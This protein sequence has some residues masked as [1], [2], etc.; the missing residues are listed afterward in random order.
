MHGKNYTCLI[1]LILKPEG[2]RPL[3]KCNCGR[4]DNIR[5]DFEKTEYKSVKWI[6]V[7]HDKS[8]SRKMCTW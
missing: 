1:I 2:K 4:E 6:D 8:N 3:R 7:A 5:M